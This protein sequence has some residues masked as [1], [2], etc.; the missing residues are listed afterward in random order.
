MIITPPADTTAPSIQGVELRAAGG[1][2]IDPALTRTIS[3]GQYTLL[4]DARDPR[5]E[6]QEGF[7][8]PHRILCSVNGLE[9]GVLNFE[10]YSARDGVLMVYRNGMVPVRQVYGSFP[11]FEIGELWLTRGQANLEIIAQDIAGNT[12]SLTFRLQVE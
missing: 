3:Q 6:G 4:V 9:V 5:G 2:R 12:R 11:F 10:T 7:L 1:S 8:A